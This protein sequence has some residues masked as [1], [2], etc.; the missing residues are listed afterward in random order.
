MNFIRKWLKP[1]AQ[2]DS[3]AADADRSSY[4]VSIMQNPGTSSSIFDSVSGTAAIIDDN[5]AVTQQLLALDDDLCDADESQGYDPYDTGRFDT[6]PAPP[7]DP[8]K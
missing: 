8:R 4:R 1:A 5:T 7:Y 2:Q 6:E 3:P